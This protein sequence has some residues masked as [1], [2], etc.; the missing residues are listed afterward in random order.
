MANRYEKYVWCE[1]GYTDPDGTNY[2]LNYNGK[3]TDASIKGFHCK[4]CGKELKSV[5][6]DFTNIEDET[7]V[8]FGSE[9][10]KYVFGAGLIRMKK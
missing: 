4:H 5:A 10:V 7:Q 6:H 3:F 1:F 8:L 2:I 9:C